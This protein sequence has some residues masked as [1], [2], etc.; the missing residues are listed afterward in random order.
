MCVVQGLKYPEQ[1]IKVLEEKA[2]L[3][4]VVSA[5]FLALDPTRDGEEGVVLTREQTD[6]EDCAQSFVDTAKNASMTGQKIIVGRF[7][8]RASI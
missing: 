5:S 3:K 8:P 6:L 2:L 1:V 7:I 4:K